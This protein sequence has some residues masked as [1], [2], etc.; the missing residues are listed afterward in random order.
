M[1]YIPLTKIN[2]QDQ[3]GSLESR[4]LILAY[5]TWLSKNI[6]YC[7]DDWCWAQGDLYAVGVYIRDEELAVMFKLTFVV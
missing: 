7:T 2:T 1:K 4:Q 6:G 5:F 3:Y